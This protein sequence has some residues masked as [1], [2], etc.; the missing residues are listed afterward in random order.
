VSRRCLVIGFAIFLAAIVLIAVL[1]TNHAR[2]SVLRIATPDAE[3]QAAV[4]KAQAG[5]PTF[6]KA[7]AERAGDS[8]FAILGRF[9]TTAG[10]EYL[11]LR[12]P[13]YTEGAFEAYL[14]QK[15]MVF[16]GRIGDR[17]T[18]SSANVYDWMI[19]RGDKIEG[20]FTNEALQ[21]RQQ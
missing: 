15:P 2:P 5:L 11:W 14:D 1:T 8:Q 9:E 20:G 6:E 4:R 17:L 18:V 10:P 7:L 3:L 16:K 12:D 21:K 13:T 19:R